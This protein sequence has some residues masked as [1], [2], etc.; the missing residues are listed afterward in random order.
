MFPYNL[1]LRVKGIIVK[2]V[3]EVTDTEQR[4]DPFAP[5]KL[6]GSDGVGLPFQLPDIPIASNYR[7]LYGERYAGIVRNSTDA[8]CPLIIGINLILGIRF[9]RQAGCLQKYRMAFQ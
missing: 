3:S 7:K 8:Q 2:N 9:Y 5:P 4:L 1:A 6:N